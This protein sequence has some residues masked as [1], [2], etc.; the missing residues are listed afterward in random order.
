[1]MNDRKIARC[2]F[3]DSVC[4]YSGFLSGACFLKQRD[5]VDLE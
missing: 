1:M 4:T 5:R 2:N 3:L